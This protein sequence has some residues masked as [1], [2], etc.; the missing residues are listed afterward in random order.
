MSTISRKSYSERDLW[1]NRPAGT[2]RIAALK[3]GVRF[4]RPTSLSREQATLAK[5]L[6]DEG[7]SAKA[8]AKTFGVNRS[9]I[10]RATAAA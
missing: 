9:T 2:G 10:Y 6:L 7:Q 1:C 8:V 3:R 5:R 4:G